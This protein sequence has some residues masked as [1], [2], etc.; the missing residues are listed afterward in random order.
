MTF[1]KTIMFKRAFWTV[2]LSIK[3]SKFHISLEEEIR[4]GFKKNEFYFHYQPK[5]KLDLTS[6]KLFATGAELLIRWKK[7]GS[8]I[9]PDIFIPIAEQNGQI[10]KFGELVIVEA[11][12]ALKLMQN[13]AMLK[14]LVLSVNISPYHICSHNFIIFLRRT[15]HAY[16]IDPTKLDIELTERATFNNYEEIQQK[17]LEIKSYGVSFSLDDFGSGNA[18]LLCLFHLPFDYIKIDRYFIDKMNDN[19]NAMFV[20]MSIRDLS[21]QMNIKVIAEGIETEEQLKTLIDNG[22]FE[23]QGYYLGKPMSKMSF[24]EFCKNHNKERNIN[25]NIFSSDLSLFATKAVNAM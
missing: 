9:S 18:S 5:T 1:Q 21:K 12:K 24:F 22:I 25:V 6:N 15:L 7:D 10:I 8:N 4:N 11:C 19:K 14:N 23:F 13:D 3:E 2:A 17:M 20:V 16:R